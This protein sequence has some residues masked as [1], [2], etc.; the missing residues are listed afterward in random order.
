MTDNQATGTKLNPFTLVMIAGMVAGGLVGLN[1]V[2]IWAAPLVCLL[3]CLGMMFIGI[4]RA[5]DGKK[6]RLEIHV[7]DYAR[8]ASINLVQYV[9]WLK[10]NVRGHDSVIDKIAT[11]VQ[12]NLTLAKPGKTLGA[13]F[14][15]GPTGTGKTFLAQLLA[16]AIYPESEVIMLRMNQYKHEDDVFTLIGP[17]PGRPGYEIGG[18]LTRPVLDQPYRVIIFDELEKCHPDLHHCLYNILDTAS[19]REK[20]SGKLVDF[21]GCAFFATCNGGA[22][23]LRTIALHTNDELGV[24]R[25]SL[26]ALVDATNFDKAFLARWTSV[27]LMDELQP[28]HVAEVAC[29]Q[30]AKYWRE[31]GIEVA[32][33][34]PEIILEAVERNE[35]FKQYGIR[36]LGAYIQMKTNDSISYAR[37]QGH[38]R[39]CLGLSAEG[40]LNVLEEK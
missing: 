12:R 30:I 10:D 32:Y 2:S 25:Q 21:S 37:S 26:D 8:L 23:A 4:L 34:S 39:V 27:H 19:C 29:L 40:Q 33:T 13:F 1:K 38:S 35:D 14:L 15:V 22:D 20:S 16:Q 36:Q 18:S 11:T 6:S 24:I 9:P 28:L 7:V 17:P 3:S 5:R 31:Y